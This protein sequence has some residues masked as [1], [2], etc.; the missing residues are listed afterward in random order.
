M[1][2]R[3][4]LRLRRVLTENVSGDLNEVPAIHFG[5]PMHNDT[6]AR[7]QIVVDG[8]PRSN[9]DTKAAALEAAELLR[10]RSGKV[11]VKD[12]KTGETVT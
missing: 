8:I 9:R 1:A 12:T 10:K 3:V 7:Y 5:S 2:Q 11:E 6:G 4:E